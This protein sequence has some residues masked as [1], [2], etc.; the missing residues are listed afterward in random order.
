MRILGILVLAAAVAGCGGG[1]G[2]NN[3]GGG[4]GG[5]DGDMAKTGTGGNG[6]DLSVAHVPADMSSGGNGGFVCGAQTCGAGTQC[7]VVGTTPMCSSSCPDGGFV[8]SCSQPSECSTGSACCLTAT[9]TPFGVESVACKPVASCVPSYN[10]L[11]GTILTRAC[12]ADSDCT[13]NNTN[14]TMFGS[15]C[16]EATTGR[17]ACFSKTLAG[18]GWTCP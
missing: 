17:K 18:N 13:D 4:G 3:G 5:G 7:C 16:T 9:A 2:G 1:S 6:S 10:V 14:H 15:C 11:S 8:A 12:V